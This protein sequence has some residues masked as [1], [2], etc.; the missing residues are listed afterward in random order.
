MPVSGCSAM[1]A[2]ISSSSELPPTSR[3]A[4]AAPHQ[5]K[6]EGAK[7]EAPAEDGHNGDGAAHQHNGDGYAQV[8]VEVSDEALGEKCRAHPQ[9][10]LL[11]Q[12][13]STI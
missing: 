2:P 12:D 7:Q 10:E 8:G 5:L 4:I 6:R 9:A 1:Y 11:D 3:K 13:D